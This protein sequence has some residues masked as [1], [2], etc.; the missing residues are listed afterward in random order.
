MSEERDEG[1]VRFGNVQGDVIGARVNGDGN[2][3][4]KNITVSGT[5][6]THSTLMSGEYARDLSEF[7]N[8][9][10][11]LFKKYNVSRE[12][13]GEIQHDIDSFT[14]EVKGIGSEKDITT[15]K[16][17]TVKGKFASFTEKIL[18]SLPRTAETIAR[19]YPISPL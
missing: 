13:I 14:N 4:G 8:R 2:V 11:E 7:E 15:A 1:G 17:M 9:I 16:K 3:F 10:N 18:K 12:Q 6:N 19:F 5:I